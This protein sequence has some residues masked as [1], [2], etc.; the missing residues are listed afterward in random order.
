L[1]GNIKGGFLGDFFMYLIQLCFMCRPSDSTVS[2]DAKTEPR[3]VATI[4]LAAYLLSNKYKVTMI[5]W[6]MC[7][8]ISRK[9]IKSSHRISI[10]E[11]RFSTAADESKYTVYMFVQYK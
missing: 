6:V 10:Y 4:A 9:Y 11:F 8:K 5:Y 7:T 1:P 2:T 3:T